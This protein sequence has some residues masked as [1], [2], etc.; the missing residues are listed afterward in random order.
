MASLKFKYLD[1]IPKP[2]HVEA[3]RIDFVN[4]D[5]FIQKDGRIPLVMLT[6]HGIFPSK[7]N[8]GSKPEYNYR[9][10]EGLE[11][12]LVGFVGI[13]YLTGNEK[14]GIIFKYTGPELVKQIAK[15]EKSINLSW[16][17]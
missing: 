6:Q 15:N 14:K 16:W 10:L 3:D 8:Y 12:R 5:E 17:S 9:L 13:A 11:D 7:Q 4:D 1:Y 2:V